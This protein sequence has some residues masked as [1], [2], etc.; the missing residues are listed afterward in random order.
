MVMVDTRTGAEV[1]GE[2]EVGPIVVSVLH[3]LY[4]RKVFQYLYNNM[5]K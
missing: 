3:L 4:A 1:V 2:E 5:K